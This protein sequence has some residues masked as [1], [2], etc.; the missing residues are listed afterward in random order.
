M[1]QH[2]A[3]EVAPRSF[4]PAANRAEAFIKSYVASHRAKG[5]AASQWRLRWDLYHG[6]A[7]VILFLIE[8]YDGEDDALLA[9]LPLRSLARGLAAVAPRLLDGGDL[10]GAARPPLGPGLYAGLAGVA[11]ALAEAWRAGAG[12]AACRAAAAACL[13]RILQTA[14]RPRACNNAGAITRPPA[15]PVPP[16][17]NGGKARDARFAQ[18]FVAAMDAATTAPADAAADTGAGEGAGEDTGAVEWNGVSDVV[19]GTAGIGLFLLHA[20]RHPCFDGALRAAALRAAT[21]AGRRLLA[22]ARPAPDVPATFSPEGASAA[23]SDLRPPPVAGQACYW[24]M[25]S[26]EGAPPFEMPNHSHGTAGV[27]SFLA[28]LFV[29]TGGRHAAFLDGALAGGRHVAAVSDAAERAR[30]GCLCAHHNPGGED[31][32]Y[33]GWCHGP[34]RQHFAE[35]YFGSNAL[36]CTATARILIPAECSAIS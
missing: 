6:M 35:H 13:R 22:L 31:L 3:P 9:L 33:L 11:F 10:A 2:V 34:A 26:G 24:L 23:A 20:G 4:Y 12:G 21:A 5:E 25:T 1:T 8:L 28:R 16:T 17:G 19:A 27:A 36:H 15:P 29:A 14:R 32:F 18:A 30:G 7:G